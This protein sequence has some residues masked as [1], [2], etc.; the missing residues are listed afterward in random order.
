MRDQATVVRVVADEVAGAAWGQP[1]TSSSLTA[2]ATDPSGSRFILRGLSGH[3][4]RGGQA[5]HGDIATRAA[6]PLLGCRSLERHG[7][8]HVD[9][10]R[11]AATASIAACGFPSAGPDLSRGGRPSPH[12]SS[13]CNGAAMNTPSTPAPE[14]GGSSMAPAL[15]PTPARFASRSAGTGARSSGAG[16]PGPSDDAARCAPRSR[17]TPSGPIPPERVLHPL[18]RVGAKGQGTGASRGTRRCRDRFSP[19]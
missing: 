14:H 8:R 17:A 10:R 9:P 6:A 1:N 12:R 19:G 11:S 5:R 13:V 15:T 16:R 2:P 7:R 3:R 18:R 4:E